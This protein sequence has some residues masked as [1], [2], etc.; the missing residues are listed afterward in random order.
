M[1]QDNDLIKLISDE[2]NEIIG[3]ILLQSLYYEENNK[4]IINYKENL[5]ESI[6]HYTSPSGLQGIIASN[7]LWFTHY[8]F[9][10][11]RGEKYYAFSIF[12][13]C[14]LEQKE[15]LNKNFYNAVLNLI[16]EGENFSQKIFYQ[17]AR[18]LPDYFIASFSLNSD[19]LNMWNYYTK[20]KNKTGYSVEYN[21]KELE[22]SL[23]NKSYNAYKV[24]YEK[25]IL[26][27]KINFYIRCFNK[28]WD[29]NRSK[30]FLH[31]LCVLLI[32]VIDAESL[33][34]KHKAFSSE[35]EFRIVFKVQDYNR[36]KFKCDKLMKFRE[37]NGIMVPFLDIGYDKQCVKGVK[38]SP[39]QQD[40]LIKEGLRM[41]FDNNGYE[42]I[43]NEKITMSDIPLRY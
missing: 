2:E 28:G 33:Q 32:E 42:N 37:L 22:A 35:E 43:P 14:L 6:Y 23:V 11:D 21:L 8:K 30:E 40:E 3:N 9:L 31:C 15:N 38:I 26:V 24:N 12:K 10:N 13:E 18:N 29:D 19:S 34:N 39:T 5:P 17:K 36:E 4:D 7:S 20:E 27:D 16:C 41:V 25:E 1:S